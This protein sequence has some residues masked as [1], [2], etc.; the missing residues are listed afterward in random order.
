MGGRAG[1]QVAGGEDPRLSS[2]RVPGPWTGLSS[3]PAAASAPWGR[4]WSRHRAPGTATRNQGPP[5]L[6]RF[7]LGTPRGSHLSLKSQ[8]SVPTSKSIAL[9]PV[10]VGVTT[11]TAPLTEAPSRQRSPR[12]QGALGPLL[13]ST[14]PLYQLLS[15]KVLTRQALV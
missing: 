7:P 12:P 14:P 15:Q 8:Y 11:Y 4:A 3:R 6:L 13:P 2:R 9:P 5:P 10:P 1:G